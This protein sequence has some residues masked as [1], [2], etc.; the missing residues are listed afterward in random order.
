MYVLYNFRGE[1]FF[2]SHKY[3]LKFLCLIIA[4]NLEYNKN[5]SGQ[6]L[7]IMYKNVNFFQETDF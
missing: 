7:P 3:E 1:K 5:I 4:L 2:I 6:K